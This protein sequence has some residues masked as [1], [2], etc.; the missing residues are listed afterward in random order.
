MF[1]Q[2]ALQV[3]GHSDIASVRRADAFQQIH[4]LH[5]RPSCAKASEGVLFALYQ[6]KQN[7]G[8]GEIRTHG[9]VAATPV[10]K[11]GALNRSATHPRIELKYLAHAKSATEQNWHRIG[12]EQ[13]PDCS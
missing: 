5:E 11:T 3:R 10:F 1:S 6:C 7:G 2:S 8:W 13:M 12:T 9:D 4:I